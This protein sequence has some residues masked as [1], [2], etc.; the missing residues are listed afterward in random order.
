MRAVS[1]MLALLLLGPAPL[2][3]QAV[4]GTLVASPGGGPVPGALVALLD[5]RGSETPGQFIP[6]K[7]G[8]GPVCGAIV[9]W[10]KRAA[11]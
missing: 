6:C 9:V 7:T 3:A 10:T 1:G 11:G 2:A 8:C 4:R 5:A